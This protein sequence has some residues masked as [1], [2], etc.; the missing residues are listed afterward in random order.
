MP[1]VPIP[2]NKPMVRV[3]QA[4][5]IYKT[6]AAKFEAA[7]DDILQQNKKG[8]PVLVGTAS[9]A[10]S[11]HLSTLL[12]RKGVPHQVLNAKQH[13]RE[14]EVV[15]QAGRLGAVTV[16]TNMAGRGVDVLLGGNPEGLAKRELEAQGVDLATEEGAAQLESLK[17]KMQAD[18]EYEGEKVRQLGG[19]YVLGSERHESRRIDNQLRGR[20]GRQGDPGESRFYLSLEDELMRLFATGAMQ[21]VM[22]RALPE[23]V[24]IETKMVSK[25]IERAQNTVEARNAEIRKDVLKYD[26]V[27]DSQ[28]KVIYARR[29]QII[30]GED[31]EQRT[32]ELIET[33]VEGVIN[34]SLPGEYEEEWDL[35]GLLRELRLYYPTEFSPEDLE[36]AHSKMHIAESVLHEALEYYRGRAEGFPGGVEQARDVEREIMLHTIS[37]RWQDHLAEMDYLREGINLRAMGQQDP[38]V[39]WQK[40]GFEMFGRLMDAIEDEYL[41]IVLQ[42]QMVTEQPV[43]E[44]DLAQATYQAAEEPI[45]EGA[46]AA[47]AGTIPMLDQADEPSARA[48]TTTLIKGVEPAQAPVV[49]DPSKKVGRNDPCYCGSNKKFKLC[50]GKA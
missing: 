26:E 5:L 4:D 1:V 43:A 27:L 17:A 7:V 33:M 44:P 40:D 19:L 28:R 21:W 31:L 50:H 35:E 16:A 47:A 13:T 14:A 8:R 9:V 23:D 22:D 20:S 29:L 34:S 24:P 37:Q 32:E 36:E 30:D 12:K 10:H 11:E 18:C 6:E 38:L 39:A 48:A 46:M 42:F 49:N 25:A 15:A 2:T 41:K 45:V 3:D